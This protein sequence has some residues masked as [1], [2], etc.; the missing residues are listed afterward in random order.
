MGRDGKMRRRFS[1]LLAAVLVALSAAA[2]EAALGPA[3]EGSFTI[4]VIPDT[5]GYRG[6]G[7][8]AEP[9]SAAPVTNVP[10]E[11]DVRWIVE[12]LQRQRIVFVSHVGDIVDRNTPNQWE[13]ARA[14]MDRL[15][16]LVP[17]AIG[18]GNHDMTATGD[19]SQFQKYFPAARFTDYAW[20]A[21]TYRGAKAEVFGNNANSCQ[22]FSAGGMDFVFLH[23][24]CNAPDEVL[25]WANE[26]LRTHGKRRA[27]ITTHMGLGPLEKP[28]TL[29]DYSDAPKGRMRWKKSYGEQGNTPQQMWD[30]CFAKNDNLFMVFS[31]D[32]SRTQALRLFTPNERGKTVHELMSDYDPRDY[33]VRVNRFL[34]GSN[35]IEIYTVDS[36][37][38]QLCRGTAKQPK[39]DQHCFVLDYNMSS[40]KDD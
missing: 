20:Y 23:L 28:K 12:N 25:T 30:K 6:Q 8:K 34:P 38:G 40:R 35:R 31:G 33:W 29:R 3:P 15:Y 16:K 4:I 11:T 24:S 9:K 13:V 5:Q 14:C 17:H 21:G 2:Q 22:L 18:V 32:Q 39:A 19:C 10:L 27:L 36:R 37:N 7:T 1:S 26:T